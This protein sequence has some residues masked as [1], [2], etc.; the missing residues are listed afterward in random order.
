VKDFILYRQPAQTP[1]LENREYKLEELEAFQGSSQFAELEGVKTGS[2]RA[3][4]E[5]GTYK[6]F[7]FSCEYYGRKPKVS[8]T[9]PLVQAKFELWQSAEHPLVIS[10]DPPK[11]VSRVAVA[12]LSLAAFRDPSLILPLKINP[13]DFLELK[14]HAEKLKGTL[15]QLVLHKVSSSGVELR[16][17][18]FIG[19]RLEKLPNLDTMLHAASEISCM[20]FVIPEFGEGGRKISFRVVE[21]GGGQIYSPADPLP[22]EISTFLDFFETTLVGRNTSK[23]QRS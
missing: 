9:Q 13:S 2:L 11:K 3:T 6:V 16:Q 15:S 23:A 7:E 20:G 1:R 8:K 17:V 22:H 5:L 4:S 18:Q 21:W 10:F 12:L 14:K 19:R